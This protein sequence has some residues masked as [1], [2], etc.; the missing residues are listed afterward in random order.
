MAKMITGIVVNNSANKT[1]VV[2]VQ[3]RRR[4][5]L[6]DKQYTVTKKYHV[7][8]PT[9]DAKVGDQVHIVESKPISKL[10]RW[11]LE[12]IVMRAADV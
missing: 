2:S 9:N 5:T 4:H 8:D 10:K 7:H 6:Y 11:R 3:E 1:I 12:S